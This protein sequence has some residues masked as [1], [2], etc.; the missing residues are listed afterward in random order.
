MHK[1]IDTTTPL[2]INEFME[3]YIARSSL[4]K[5]CNNVNDYKK[6]NT[7][8]L[9]TYINKKIQKQEISR[10]PNFTNESSICK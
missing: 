9:N 6:N 5:R 1:Y 4:K 8:I 10:K 2:C 3:L 7:I